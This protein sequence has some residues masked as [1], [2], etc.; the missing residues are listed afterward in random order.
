MRAF[1]RIW[2]LPRRCGCWCGTAKAHSDCRLSMT[3]TA[4]F[5][6]GAGPGP[7]AV[8]Q[9]VGKESWTCNREDQR[10]IGNTSPSTELQSI[11]AAA[12]PP[13]FYL[14]QLHFRPLYPRLHKTR[15]FWKCS[16]RQSSV[17]ERTMYRWYY[18]CGSLAVSGNRES[19]K[20]LRF[21]NILYLSFLWS[22]S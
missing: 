18:I 17:A 8:C 12:S 16:S 7:T 13:Y 6:S 15:D 21:W 9:A 2:E 4:W 10:Q 19:L 5:H 3:I 1:R 20:S 14:R 11:M 22:A